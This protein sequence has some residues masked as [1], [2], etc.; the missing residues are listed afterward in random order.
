M[1]HMASVIIIQEHAE[2]ASDIWFHDFRALFQENV[3]EFIYIE[4]ISL[5][6]ESYV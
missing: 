2:R 4:A 5:T 6:G 3:D 1:T